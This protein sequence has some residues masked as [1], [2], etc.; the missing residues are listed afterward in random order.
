MAE[1]SLDITGLVCPLTFVK[2][3][4]KLEEMAVGDTLVI[5]LR[6]AEPAENVPRS[7]RDHGHEVLEMREVAAGC[8]ELVVRKD[9]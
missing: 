5:R 3:K 1:Y 8:T 4:L 6:G 9:R 2:T 7:L